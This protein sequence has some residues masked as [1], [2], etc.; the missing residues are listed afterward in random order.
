MKAEAVKLYL[1]FRVEHFR[2]EHF[3]ADERGEGAYYA[4]PPAASD[5]EILS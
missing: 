5:Q 3:R 1:Y 2:A 4:L